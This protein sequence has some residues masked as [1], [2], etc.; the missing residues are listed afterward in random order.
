M[1]I[2]TLVRRMLKGLAA[3]V[4]LCAVGVTALL[5][6]LWIEHKTPIS[7]P[8][9][10]G[11]YAVGRTTTFWTTDTEDK[12]APTPGTKLQSLSPLPPAHTP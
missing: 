11:P 7:L 10:T 4:I 6:A 1:A 3:L 12:S 9:P 8:T 2:A 5:C